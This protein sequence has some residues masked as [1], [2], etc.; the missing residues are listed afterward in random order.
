M[1]TLASSGLPHHFSRHR[2]RNLQE[3]NSPSWYN[4]EEAIQVVEY[5]ALLLKETKP[6]LKAED[7]GIITP[8]NR[9]AQKI[10]T[11]LDKKNLGKDI[12]VGSVDLSGAREALYY[13]F[14]GSI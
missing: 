9:Q 13:S 7:I 6:P 4:P 8:Y 11:A 12:K 1:G 14:D 10:R 5:V 3:G 2:W